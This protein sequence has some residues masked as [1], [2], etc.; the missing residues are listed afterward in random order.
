MFKEGNKDSWKNDLFIIKYNYEQ[1]NGE[2]E[3][4]GGRA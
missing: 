1:F 4:G 2:G 3:E